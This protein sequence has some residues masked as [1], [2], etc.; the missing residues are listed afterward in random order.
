MVHQKKGLCSAVNV[1]LQQNW[2][3]DIYSN[4][5]WSKY[6]RSSVLTVRRPG[7]LPGPKCHSTIIGLPDHQ[8]WW[9][10]S[11]FW[12]DMTLAEQAKGPASEGMTAGVDAKA[13]RALRRHSG[14][15]TAGHGCRRWESGAAATAEALVK[16][17]HVQT[18]AQ[19]ILD[20]SD[21]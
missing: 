10:E 15:A 11:D 12:V 13:D 2:N 6:W 16:V 1:S 20:R 18:S 5:V 9:Q 7:S 14:K 4:A 21:S 17:Q 19:Q 8:Q 3:V